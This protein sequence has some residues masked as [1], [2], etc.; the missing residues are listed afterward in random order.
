M[1]SASSFVAGEHSAPPHAIHVAAVS[2]ACEPNP[3][4]HCEVQPHNSPEPSAFP[5]PHDDSFCEVSP[6]ACVEPISPSCEAFFPDTMSQGVRDDVTCSRVLQLLRRASWPSAAP[7]RDIATPSGSGLTGYWNFGVRASDRSS[8]TNVTSALPRVLQELNLLL[9]KLWPTGSW[10]AV[11][12]AC[13]RETSMHRDLANAEHSSNFSVSLGDFTGGRLWVQ[14]AE[15]SSFRAV[16]GVADPIPGVEVST[17]NAP[18]CFDPTLWHCTLPFVGERWA[19]TCYTLA[20]VPP[21]ILAGFNFPYATENSSSQAS[22]MAALPEGPQAFEAQCAGSSDRLPSPPPVMGASARPQFFLDIC[23]GASAPLSE[24]AAQLGISSIP[25]DILRRAGDN[26]LDDTV[27]DGLLKLS[28]SGCIVFAHGSPPCSEY[29]LIKHLGPGPSPCRSFEHVAGLPGNDEAAQAR[30]DS[31]HLLMRRTVSILHAVYQSG[32]H[33]CL[34]QPRNSIAWVEPVVQSFLLDIAADLIQVPACRFGVNLKKHWLLASSWRPLQQLQ[35]VCEHE[36]GFHPAF[37]GK[38]DA[39]GTFLSRNTSV[40]PVQMCAMYM[41]AIAPLFSELQPDAIASHVSWPEALASLPHRPVDD[42]PVAQQDGGGIYSS[43]DWTSPPPGVSDIFRGLRNELMQFFATRGVF[44]RLRKHVAESSRQPLFDEAEVSAMRGFW[45]SWFRSQGF[46]EDISWQVPEDQPYCLYALEKLSQALHDRDAALWPDLQAGVPTGVDGDISMSNC[47]LPSPSDFDPTS[48]DV[49]ICSGNWPG[50]NE[51]P[52]LLD[53]MVQQEY[54]AGYLHKCDSLA[55]AQARWPRVAVGK[56]NL[57]KSPNRSPRL[58]V[59]PSISG[60]NP[61]CHLPERFLLPG[62]GDVRLAYPL[63]GCSS[64]VAAASLDI[65]AAH[66]T[67]RIRASEQGLLGFC[68]RGK[69]YFYKVAPFGGSFS[70]LWWQRVAGF[71]V[72]VCHRLVYIS[73]IFLMYVDDAL[74]LQRKE[75]IEFSTLLILS[76]SQVFGYPLSWRKLQLGPRVE[77]IGWS[78][79]FRAGFYELPQAK[80]QKFLQALTAVASGDTC[81]KQALQR[82][83]GLMH[84]ILQI[85]LTLLPWLCTLYHDLARPLGTNFSLQAGT[86]Q[87]LP[88][89]LDDGMI[90]QRTPPGTSIR[91][92]SKL[93]SVRHKDINSKDDLKLVRCTGKRLWA[94]IADPSTSKRKVSKGS[95]IFIQFWIAWCLRPQMPVSL[96]VP[97]MDFQY[98]LAADAFAKGEDIG[99]GGWVQLPN[100]P[101]IWFSER[102]KVHEFLALGLPMQTNANLDITSYETLAQLALVVCFSS[103]TAA[104]RLRVRI[105]SWSDNSGTESVANKLFTVR[106]PICYFAQRLATLAWRSGITLDCSHIAGCH[107]D[108]ADFLSRWDGDLSKLP[109]T[110]SLDYRVNCSLPVIWDGERD[111]RVFPDARALQWQPPQSSLR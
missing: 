76:F 34:E 103:F 10:N 57:I 77:Y 60:V 15:G 111:V 83:I 87:Q 20:D 48:F 3:V 81:T 47:F 89:F 106:S 4:D 51:D 37:H 96:A 72:R 101:C 88:S 74:L 75:V 7:C 11:C 1:P 36:S 79:N 38:R 24:A 55:E 108:S 33:V 26:L 17:H 41:R 67:V 13:N 105:A 35:G 84:W 25:F 27:Y 23:S 30:V 95:S 39:E 22:A 58:I 69:Y 14:E 43:P 21:A 9:A 59:D 90:F 73:H 104:G 2:K 92:G 29:S 44:D 78:L 100:Q 62:L 71:Y 93:L 102:F 31:S 49:Q 109:D 61:S 94:R 99:I 12:V 28:L 82:L 32:G 85:A 40:F 19:I 91:A 46:S 97:A 52:E 53:A 42:F 68:V 45:E 50:A 8:L 110:W 70:A 5:L 86:W 66:K 63:R 98:K 80:V 56:V 16:P 65:A 18:I 64:E 107:S 6:S 54:E